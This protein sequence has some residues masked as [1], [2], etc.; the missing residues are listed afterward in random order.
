VVRHMA[1]DVEQVHWMSPSG[2]VLIVTDALR[3][4]HHSNAHFADVDAGML[5]GGHHTPLPCPRTPSPPP[6]NNTPGRR[7]VVFPAGRR[8]VALRSAGLG[9]PH[10][11]RWP[12]S[13]Q[14]PEIRGEAHRRARGHTLPGFRTPQYPQMREK[15][16][17]T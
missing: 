17:G 6:G 15:V 11:P 1:S 2:Q 3:G 8:G 9:R 5:T 4:R 7:T 10:M 14:T 12:V 13:G 16:Y